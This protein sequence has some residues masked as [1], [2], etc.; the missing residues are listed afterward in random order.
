MSYFFNLDLR[1]LGNFF[2]QLSLTPEWSFGCCFLNKAGIV[3][4]SNR[5]KVSVLWTLLGKECPKRRLR[6][7]S[8]LILE[9]W[10]VS[11]PGGFPDLY[12]AHFITNFIV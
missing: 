1:T 9:D 6:G 3:S 12:V 10:E 2:I 7:G 11:S 4:I 8:S 5:G